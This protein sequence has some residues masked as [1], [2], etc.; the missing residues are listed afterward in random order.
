MEQIGRYTD[1]RLY[2][3]CHEDCHW[4]FHVLAFEQKKS[5]HHERTDGNTETFRKIIHKILI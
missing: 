5:D 1:A 3:S 4:L 2:H